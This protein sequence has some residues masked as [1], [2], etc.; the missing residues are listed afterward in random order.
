MSLTILWYW[1]DES[2]MTEI[3][4]KKQRGH[5]GR[6]DDTDDG[7]TGNNNISK[8]YSNAHNVCF[9]MGFG[10][11]ASLFMCV[12][13]CVI[14]MSECQFRFYMQISWGAQ[15]LRILNSDFLSVSFTLF[16]QLFLLNIHKHENIQW[17]Y[18]N[19]AQ[20]K[21][22]TKAKSLFSP[23]SSCV[24]CSLNRFR[25]RSGSKIK[26]YKCT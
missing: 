3:S 15:P 26:L 20:K 22:T 24:S 21:G 10:W 6:M 13:L 14:C 11:Y 25:W 4:Q 23:Y 2:S 9:S 8:L 1:I 19:P 5:F 17:E 16:W 18:D 12:S 7:D